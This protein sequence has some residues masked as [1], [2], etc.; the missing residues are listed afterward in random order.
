MNVLFVCLGNI[1]RSPTAQAVLNK[2][3]H[4]YSLD[5]EVDSAGTAA[6]HIGKCPDPRTQQ[7]A[8][9]RGMD[10]SALSARQVELQD[11]Y[12]FDFIFAMDKA[13]YE[14]LLLLQP[15]DGRATLALFLERYGRLGVD[16]VPD[17]YY[18]GQQGFETVLDL[19]ENASDAFLK[20]QGLL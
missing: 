4:Q 6:Y 19:L 11:F 14:E 18:G 16:E 2:S 12:R 8:L 5:I 20:S 10:M 7:A 3:I 15:A 13:N 17:P 1:C 9:N